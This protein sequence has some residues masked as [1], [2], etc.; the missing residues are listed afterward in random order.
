[1]LSPSLQRSVSRFPPRLS[2]ATSC[3]PFHPPAPTQPARTQRPGRRTTRTRMRRQSKEEEEEELSEE[4]AEGEGGEDPLLW[5]PWTKRRCIPIRRWWTE[6][7]RPVK[8][9]MRAGRRFEEGWTGFKLKHPTHTH[10]QSCESNSDVQQYWLPSQIPFITEAKH[11]REKF[12]EVALTTT[13][14]CLKRPLM[15]VY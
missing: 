4:Q 8:T 3:L 11:K 2:Y 10:T 5:W 1:M 14:P 6:R 7:T 13:L 9:V 12:I 15:W